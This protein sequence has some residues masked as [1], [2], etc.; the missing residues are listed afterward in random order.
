MGKE[1]G[2]GGGR[3]PI[4]IKSWVIYQAHAVEIEGGRTLCIGGTFDYVCI[5]WWG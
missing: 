1:G 5:T 3:R 2:G 4:A